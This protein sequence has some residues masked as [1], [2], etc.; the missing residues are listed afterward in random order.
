M[1]FTAHCHHSV[2]SVCS[3]PTRALTSQNFVFYPFFF[4]SQ[5]RDYQ[6]EGVNWLVF[7]WLQ[8]RGSILA[9]EMGLGK[10]VQAT[11]FLQ[12][13]SQVIGLFCSLAGL[14]FRNAGLF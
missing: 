8:H 6:K 3:K 4:P 5:L 12:W 2:V 11:G 13:L 1:Y 9:D 14:F 7:N 10:T